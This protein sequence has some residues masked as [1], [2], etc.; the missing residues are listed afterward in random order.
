MILFYI[1]SINI[2]WFTSIMMAMRT[3]RAIH[4]PAHSAE[5]SSTTITK[6]S[7]YTEW[8]NVMSIMAHSCTVFANASTFMKVARIACVKW[9]IDHSS[10]CFSVS[11][12][13][14]L[15]LLSILIIKLR[16]ARWN[17]HTSAVRASWNSPWSAVT[18][19]FGVSAWNKLVTCVANSCTCFTASKIVDEAACDA[20]VERLPHRVI[21]RA[22]ICAWSINKWLWA[23]LLIIRWWL[24]VIVWELV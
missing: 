24:I 11:A 16:L 3:R 7:S 17:F 14:N 19:T 18:I 6:S 5:I 4:A 9:L 13:R 1:A 23:R 2:N 22:I 12:L 8:S 15:L 10:S 21:M 20:V